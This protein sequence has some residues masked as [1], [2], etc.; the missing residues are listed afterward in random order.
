MIR[1]KQAEKENPLKEGFLVYEN[2]TYGI[3]MQYPSHWI[4]YETNEQ[5]KD[6]VSVI[7]FRTTIENKSPLLPYLLIRSQKITYH[8]VNLLIRR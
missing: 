1:F 2:M 8:C 3:R 4:E 5:E 7:E 6:F